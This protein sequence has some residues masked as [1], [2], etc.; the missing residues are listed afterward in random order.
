[1]K[2]IAGVIVI[3][4]SVFLIAV[5]PA[6]ARGRGGGGRGGGFHHGGFHHGFHGHHGFHPG[7]RTRVFIG[8]GWGPYWYPPY[9]APYYPPVYT[10]PVVEEPATYIE[11]SPAPSY[12]YY[13][14][15][16][17][18]YYPYVQQCPGGW[19]TVVPPTTEAQP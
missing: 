5:A 16:A 12:W 17:R 18:A 13:C 10:T 11:Q 7:F 3:M 15:S 19:L 9:Y 4:A 8:P 14:E 1:M 2:K 6:D